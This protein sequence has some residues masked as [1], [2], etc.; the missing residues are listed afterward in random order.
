MFEIKE[1]KEASPV[2]GDA[3]RKTVS[4]HP[5]ERVAAQETVEIFRRHRNGFPRTDKHD[6]LWQMFQHLKEKPNDVLKLYVGERVA[7]KQH[8]AQVYAERE[9]LDIKTRTR[10]GWLYVRRNIQL[11][12]PKK[13]Y[14]VTTL[15]EMREWARRA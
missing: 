7:K 2:S 3:E 13:P 1:Y 15:A 10:D 4:T 8:T 12:Q 11:P 5:F 14:Q 9:K 6:D